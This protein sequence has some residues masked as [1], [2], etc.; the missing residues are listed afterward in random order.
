MTGPFL[1]SPPFRVLTLSG[2]TVLVLACLFPPSDA[3]ASASVFLLG[4]MDVLEAKPVILCCSQ[5]KPL[6]RSNGEST[7]G[8]QGEVCEGR[9]CQA[10]C[11]ET[12]V[13]HS[14][15]GQVEDTFWPDVQ[16]Q[17][18]ILLLSVKLV[19]ESAL[20]L[21]PMLEATYTC[22]RRCEVVAL[23]GGISEQI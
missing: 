4:A 5:R 10:M 13:S 8:N 12:R 11:G 23:R 15:N 6:K 9:P 14:S 3:S 16:G 18:M 20:G 2:A 21:S 19:R 7:E 17:E 22:G 1:T